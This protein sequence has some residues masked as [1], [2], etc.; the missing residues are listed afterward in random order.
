MKNKIWCWSLTPVSFRPFAGFF[1]FSSWASLLLSQ[2]SGN[3]NQ[4]CLMLVTYGSFGLSLSLNNFQNW[5]SWGI[6]AI[7]YVPIWSKRE[8]LYIA[9]PDILVR[10]IWS[11]CRILV[12]LAQRLAFS[13]VFD[14]KYSDRVLIAP[15]VLLGE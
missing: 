8:R 1:G 15:L 7:W 13:F 14:K 12:F 11:W 5:C 9:R 6:T 2:S 4:I 3:L 10:D